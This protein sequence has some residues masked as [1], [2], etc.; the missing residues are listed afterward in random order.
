MFRLGSAKVW[1]NLC[2]ADVTCTVTLG[3]QNELE[4][5]KKVL[6]SEEQILTCSTVSVYMCNYTVDINGSIYS[7]VV[8]SGRTA[9]LKGEIL[10]L[11]FDL[12]H[13]L[14]L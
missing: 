2:T 6:N 12:S 9:N 4:V 11:R 14:S 8:I 1:E 5:K 10:Y 13:Y 7:R 3:L